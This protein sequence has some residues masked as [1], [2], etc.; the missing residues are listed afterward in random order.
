MTT[1][2]HRR[3]RQLGVLAG[4]LALAAGAFVGVASA[5]AKPHPSGGP[6]TL[7]HF[8]CYQARESGLK[9]GANVLLENALQ[10]NPFAPKFLGNYWHCNPANKS[11]PVGVFVAKHPLAHL[12]CIG[13]EYS[14]TGA[15]VLLTNQFG[16]AVMTVSAP[17]DLCLPSWKSN[18]G[19][20]GM[21]P[22]APS[23]VLD[24]HTC[25]SVKALA[26]S[27]GFKIPSFVKA[28]DEFSYPKYVALHLG[29]ADLL[30][31]PTTK[32]NAGV[33]YPPISSSDPSLVCFPTSATPIWPAVW[34][35]NQF[36]TAKVFPYTAGEQLCLPST[37]SIQKPGG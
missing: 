29:I 24:H 21:T 6:E 28:E 33:A 22:N 2:F 11:V 36:G 8:L 30:C 4:A 27:Y 31:V 32:I 37:M 35:Q 10:P 5:T 23:A 13:I 3:A 25:Y 34:D 19:P 12:F 9:P 1:R 17:K 7:G 20:P 18:L 26:S 16:K 14:F 15:V